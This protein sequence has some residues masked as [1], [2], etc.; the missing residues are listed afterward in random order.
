MFGYSLGMAVLN[1]R[2]AVQAAE[3]LSALLPGG[4]QLT[5]YDQGYTAAARPIRAIESAAQAIT[6]AAALGSLAVLVLFA[7]LFVGRQRE[8]V[9]VLVSLGT[10]GEKIRLW[11]LSG[12]SVVSGTA[13]LAGAVIGS[14]T[15]SRVVTA[16]MEMAERL[17]NRDTRYS[18]AAMGMV[19][20]T[21]E[22]GTI[23]D[24]PA[25]MAGVAVFFAALALCLIFLH[26]AR[27]EN[28][29]KKGQVSVRVPRGRTSIGGRG[30]LRFALLSARR[31]GRRSVVVVAA[32]LVLTLFVSILSASAQ[33]WSD[34]VDS[35]YADSVLDGRIVS[36]NGRKQTG[37]GIPTRDIQQLWKSGYLGDISV[38]LSWPYEYTLE[39]SLPNI[40]LFVPEDKATAMKV[41]RLPILST[42]NSLSAAAEFYYT[43]RPEVRWLEGWD[44]SCLSDD[45]HPSVVESIYTWLYENEYVPSDYI[46]PVLAG[47]RFLENNSLKLGD[48]MTFK[49]YMYLYVDNKE[50][51][52]EWPASFRIVGS[53]T[54]V[55]SKDNVYAPLSFWCSSEWLYGEGDK[56][57]PNRDLGRILN[58][59]D[60]ERSFYFRS[61]FETCRF[62]LN[63]AYELENLRSWLAK[64]QYSQVSIVNNNRIA[65]LLR[66]QNFME[67][68]G[69]LN[70]YISFSNIL[71]PVLFLVVGLMGFIISWL[72]VSSRRMELAV[73]RG[74]GASPWR[75]FVSFFLEQTAL[76]LLGCLI[77][78]LAMSL[79][80][81]GMAVWLAGAGFLVCY[82]AGCALSVLAAGRTNL[83]MLLSERE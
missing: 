47:S 33:S 12:A 39:Q 24:W 57:M 62:T 65:I 73:M 81:P 38:S 35:L 8:T 83:M 34:Q 17:Y 51:L 4:V 6:L 80:R 46:Y 16:A 55:S 70:R 79:L 74:L 29:P 11:L 60:L 28:A 68:V 36:L 44:E 23:P 43:D 25:L 40:S 53:F 1:N 20:E 64:Q 56:E 13:A 63:S 10:P 37:L 52:I 7:F 75:V 18:E 67:T 32:A 42:V 19:K 82:L 72:M 9:G 22:I 27:K 69:G 78:A 41:R 21:D 58:V 59:N 77:G 76:C 49:L 14:L 54:T 26:H 48:I 66:D 50:V 61:R 3:K 5:L 15:L 71:F 31:G 30:S 2:K 45:S